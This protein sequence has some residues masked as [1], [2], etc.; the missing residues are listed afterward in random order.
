MD[1]REGQ[2][3]ASG[4]VLLQLRAPDLTADLEAARVKVRT[5]RELLNRQS[6][7]PALQGAALRLQWE[8]ANERLAGAE[9]A[10]EALTIRAVF[11]GLVTDLGP[12]IDAGVWIGRGARLLHLVGNAISRGEAFVGDADLSR[13]Q[14]GASARFVPG[15]PELEPVL[16][17]VEAVDP[18]N[19]ATFDQTTLASTYGG[20][21][22][23]YEL[24]RGGL[25]PVEATY[26]VRLTQCTSVVQGREMT[27]RVFI[28]VA[29]QSIASDVWRQLVGWGRREFAF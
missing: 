11:D 4:A 21:V 18:V 23:T 14:P 10:V 29:P 6:L 26:R 20:P 25:A 12:D 22:P 24:S 27:G 8:A 7:D 17:D 15:V 16:C 9:R 19:W 1:L 28:E 3:V 5:L 2:R 13:I